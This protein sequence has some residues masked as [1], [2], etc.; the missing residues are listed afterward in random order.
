M[1]YT[2]DYTYAHFTYDENIVFTIEE[3]FIW[4]RKK[5]IDS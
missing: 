5:G 4:I 3:W 1:R 2:K